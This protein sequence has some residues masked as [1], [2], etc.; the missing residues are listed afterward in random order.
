MQNGEII[1][2]AQDG[3]KVAEVLLTASAVHEEE[4]MRSDFVRLS[5]MDERRY[6][7]PAGSYII[8]FEW[9]LDISGQPAKF[10]LLTTYQPE[11][12]ANGYKYEPQFQ[13]P[14]MW[15]GYVP[16][17]FHTQ[18]ASGNNIEQT[19]YPYVGSIKTLLVEVCDF[20]NGCFGLPAAG[21][22][23]TDMTD[24]QRAASTSILVYPIGID[25]EQTISITF[26]DMD[27]LSALSEIAKV[28]EC[29]CHLDWQTKLL[30]FGIVRLGVTPYELS[31][32][33]N[34]GPPSVTTSNDKI[35]NCWL[36]HGSTRN[37]T[38]ETETTNIAVKQP[39]TLDATAY[40]GSVI[41]G[42]ESDGH[43]GKLGPKLTEILTLDDVYPTYELYLYDLIERRK[44]KTDDEGENTSE[45]WSVWYV[46]LARKVNGVYEDFKITTSA[47][48][49]VGAHDD[50]TRRITFADSYNTGYL[51]GAA[52]ML[53]VGLNSYEVTVED[54]N[55][56]LSFIAPA[57]IYDNIKNDGTVLLFTSGFNLDLLPA[58][59]LKGVTVDGLAPTLAMKINTASGAV[60]SLLGTRE[61]EVNFHAGEVTFSESDDVEIEGETKIIDEGTH[62]EAYKGANIGSG[63]YEIIHTTEGTD[64]IIIPMESGSGNI[65]PQAPYG[66]TSA[67]IVKNNKCTIF[68]IAIDAATKRQA[69]AELLTRAQAE[70]ADEL[71]DVNNYTFKANEVAF[72]N[73]VP[74]LYIGRR[75]SFDGNGMPLTTRVLKL[76]TRLDSLILRSQTTDNHYGQE[77]TVGNS[78]I[79][80]MGERLQD[81][82]W[83]L[84]HDFDNWTTAVVSG[85]EEV[86]EVLQQIVTDRGQWVRGRLYYYETYNR[87]TGKTE[88]SR[89]WRWGLQWECRKSLTAEEPGFGCI[90]WLLISDVELELRI[91]LEGNG[92]IAPGETDT[93]YLSVYMGSQDVTE[94]FTDMSAARDDGDEDFASA[95]SD[96]GDSWELPYADAAF[97]RNGETIDEVTFTIS[98]G[99]GAGN[100]LTGTFVEKRAS[101]TYKEFG[102]WQVGRTYT[103]EF[104]HF[105]DLSPRIIP[106]VR[107]FGIL[108]GLAVLYTSSAPYYGCTDWEPISGNLQKLEIELSK[109]EWMAFGEENELTCKAL[110]GD[111]DI[112]EQID[113]WTI[114]RDSGDPA[115]DRVW[116]GKA[117]VLAFDGTLTLV[118]DNSADNDL[119]A[120]VPTTF[121]I[122]ARKDGA[123]VAMGEI[124]V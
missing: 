9:V 32:E 31:V 51:T 67:N 104:D 36:V 116:N 114:T 81:E 30:Y 102:A 73:D 23:A 20:I 79:K 75:V 91:E 93:V 50:E 122:E 103:K 2:Y 10:Q 61:L 69:Q 15:L 29:E 121:H 108:W 72:E 21:A 106:A 12:T 6:D 11:R 101:L 53:S 82:L 14:K 3:S 99:D 113:T 87:A 71:T 117:K 7:L 85:K 18:D 86:V 42:R 118:Y 92:T 76:V 39:L 107:R 58:K 100:V 48:F 124:T 26:K 88:T 38:R 54:N 60:V 22:I 25:V 120:D 123:V 56:L 110:Y 66:I 64:N 70:I 24:A 83:A 5:W 13:H 62:K 44:Y 45:T 17:V 49:T 63:W 40:P 35:Y 8:P 33:G 96:T 43:G 65:V 77:I 41:D 4:L 80:G 34:V 94:R 105:D 111:E 97:V 52:Q 59:N 95:H 68:N 84:Q 47:R 27:V 16:M 78:L 28:C 37:N 112:T 119:G 55:G 109:G 74:A 1:I 46:R 19:E 90:D 98:A 115:D 89:V 57:A